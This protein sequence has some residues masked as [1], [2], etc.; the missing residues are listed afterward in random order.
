MCQDFTFTWIMLSQTI[1]LIRDG[2]WPARCWDIPS[3]IRAETKYIF[4][5]SALI[6]QFLASF[7]PNSQYPD[8]I[9]CCRQAC[10]S[11]GCPSY[12]RLFQLLSVFSL[13]AGW[14]CWRM[15]SAD[16]CWQGAV[17]VPG[18]W[19]VHT[20]TL[21]ISMQNRQF[22]SINRNYEQRNVYTLTDFVVPENS[23]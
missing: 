9:A 20:R 23:E 6:V 16:V 13:D 3:L 1:L 21:W 10:L 4:I 18:T 7:A 11:Q 8:K 5:I 15:P 14:R 22:K 19:Q 12:L 2:C 17:L